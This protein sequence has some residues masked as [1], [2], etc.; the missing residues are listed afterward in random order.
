MTNKKRCKS[1]CWYKLAEHNNMGYKTIRN[2]ELKL[3]IPIFFSPKILKYLTSF[4]SH[5]FLH[6]IY[7]Y[8]TLLLGML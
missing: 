7:F 1:H 3:L 5:K 4:L 6:L 8:L 2:Q